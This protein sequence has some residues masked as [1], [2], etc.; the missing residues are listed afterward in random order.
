MSL[1]VGELSDHERAGCLRARL[2]QTLVTRFARSADDLDPFG[3]IDEGGDST[4][5]GVLP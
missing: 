4:H 5:R 1:G 2:T 3:L